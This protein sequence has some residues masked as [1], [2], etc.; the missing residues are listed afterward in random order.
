ML[1]DN[2]MSDNESMNESMSD[3][4][5]KVDIH[6]KVFDGSVDLQMRKVCIALPKSLLITKSLKLAHLFEQL[7]R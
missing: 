1:E 3:S 5:V 4:D 2:F 7:F 6:F